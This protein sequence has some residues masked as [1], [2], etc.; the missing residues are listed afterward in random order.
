MHQKGWRGEG[1]MT[2]SQLQH[3]KSIYLFAEAEIRF[4]IT[5]LKFCWKG[6]GDKLSQ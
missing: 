4:I 5:T 6:L 2:A 3:T 1:G